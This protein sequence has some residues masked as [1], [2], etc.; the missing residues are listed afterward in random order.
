MNLDITGARIYYTIPVLGGIPITESI[1]NGLLVT[2][3]ILGVCIFLTRDLKLRAV[4]TRQVIAEFIVETAVNFIESNVGSALTH[5]API[6]AALF[7]MS[8]VSSLI[9]LVGL[10]PPSSDLS[11]TLAWALVVFGVI[12][13][14]KIKTNGFGGYLKGFTEPIFVFT[15]LNIVSEIFTPVAM[16]FRHFGN[17]MAG[18]VI[19]ALVYGALAVA[20]SALLGILPGVL[21]DILG[22]IPILQVGIPAVLSIYFDLF[23]SFMQAFIFCMLTVQ[24]VGQAAN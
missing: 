2:L 18:S 20:S 17:I 8:I 12:T 9:S 1:V 22:V 13:L 10:Y 19:S 21:G 5:L 3:L 15:P 11:C 23:S 7:S 16:A 14:T 4:S 24:F 6:V